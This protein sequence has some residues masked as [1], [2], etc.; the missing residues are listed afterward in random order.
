MTASE[1][2]DCAVIG[3]G[4]IGLAC[5]RAL[6]RAGREV[7]ILEATDAIG[8]GISARNSEVIHAGLYYPTGSLKARLC[9]EG[10]RRLYPFL[11][12]HGVDHKRCGKL[13]VATEE[14][15]LPALAA[16]KEKAAANGVDDLAW[17]D[18]PALRSEEP[19]LRAAAALLSLSSG[20]LDAHG[21]MLALLA[22]A[23]DAGAILALRSP[24]EGG[25]VHE[26]G[27]ELEA[28]GLSLSC[29]AVVL[30]A[31]LEA[32][33]VAGRLMGLP[34]KTVPRR[35]LA[36]GSYFALSGPSPFSRPIYPLPEAA[37]LGIHLTPDL[38]G[39]A[40]FGPDVEWVEAIDYR[41][42]PARAPLFEEAVR[43]YWPGLPEDALTPDFAGIRP[44]VQ[45]PGEPPADFVIQG[46]RDH[47]VEGLVALYGIES[48][49]LT[50][51]LAIAS[52][53]AAVLGHEDGTL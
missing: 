19:D 29:K 44:K 10:R 11:E 51:C 2:I 26:D 37:G 21:L 52:R 30:G 17:L 13:V 1:T 45:A 27:I 15:Q 7:V 6:A 20:I 35:Y 38:G 48:P 14:A 33:A 32:Q 3:A 47:G 46:P 25:H 43:R 8:T 39:R 16:L 41:V 28:G 12:E 40:R 53:V 24:V 36:K 34:G 42:D 31:G 4:V 23:E 22:D 18:A 5:A 49:G 50:A 9:V